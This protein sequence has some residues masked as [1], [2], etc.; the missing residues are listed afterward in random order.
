[1][2]AKCYFSRSFSGLPPFLR[3]LTYIC[4]VSTHTSHV[5]VIEDTQTLTTFSFYHQTRYSGAI[6]NDIEYFNRT[7]LQSL[8]WID[9][10]G[11]EIPCDGNPFGFGCRY[12]NGSHY[13]TEKYGLEGQDLSLFLDR[14]F[15]LGVIFVFPFGLLLL[16]LVFYLVPLPA[17]VKAKFRE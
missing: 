17:F 16:N 2:I 8:T 15:N 10:N 5:S 7:S 6:L 13:L 9:D 11:H 14:W 3:H 1:M 12:L 4:Q